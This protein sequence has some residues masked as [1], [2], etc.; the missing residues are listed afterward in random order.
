MLWELLICLVKPCNKNLKY[1]KCYAF[2][3][4]HKDID[5]K[6]KR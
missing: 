5:S 4:Y 6:V 2:G 1:F 3:V